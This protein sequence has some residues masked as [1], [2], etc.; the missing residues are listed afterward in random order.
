MKILNYKKTFSILWLLIVFLSASLTASALPT[1]KP[2]QSILTVVEDVKKTVTESEGKITDEALDAKL[3]SVIFP[4]FDFEMMS[5][6]CLGANWPKATAEQQKQFVTLFSELL[7]RNYLKRIKE[8]AKDSVFKIESENLKDDK[9]S[10][11]TTATNKDQVLKIEYRLDGSTA[12]WKIYDVII[13]S[14]GL[15]TNYRTEFSST[16]RKDGFDGLIKSLNDKVNSKEES[17]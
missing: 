10:I 17:K 15:V 13:E 8:N 14:V 7:S 1:V 9:A 5:K 16:I 2:S 6:M 4:A 12:Q 3:K 11:R